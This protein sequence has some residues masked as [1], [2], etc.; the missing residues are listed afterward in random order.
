MNSPISFLLSLQMSFLETLPRDIWTSITSFLSIKEL[1]IVTFTNIQL[2]GTVSISVNSTYDIT[3]YNF[4]TV[5]YNQSYTK[6]NMPFLHFPNLIR[7]ETHYQSDI[8]A[9]ELLP[10]LESL[11]LLQSLSIPNWN[12][13][14]PEQLREY[15]A[16][17]FNLIELKIPD[18]LASN[19]VYPPYLQSLTL[20]IIDNNDFL[21]STLTTLRVYR[22]YSS[23]ARFS[24]LTEL[25]TLIVYRIGNM[26]LP[27]DLLRNLPRGLTSLTLRELEDPVNYILL[28]SYLT[29]LDMRD[30]Q[31]KL[32]DI[33]Y[34]PQSL[35]YLNVL[36]EP[37]PGLLDALGKYLTKLE[38]FYTENSVL[39]SELDEMSHIASF[40]GPLVRKRFPPT[41][42]KLRVY[43]FISNIY[44]LPENLLKLDIDY[45]KV[46]TDENLQ[47]LSRELQSL[48][49][50]NS[51]EYPNVDASS[52]RYLPR[53]LTKLRVSLSVQENYL[54][55]ELLPPNLVNLIMNIYDDR[56]TSRDMAALP[57]SLTALNVRVGRNIANKLH[58]KAQD[59]SYLPRG[60]RN[61]KLNAILPNSEITHLPSGLLGLRVREPLLANLQTER[62]L[63]T[64]CPDLL[65]YNFI[66]LQC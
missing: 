63:L 22:F 20:G 1:N 44:T 15:F 48:V 25:T 43:Y 38:A 12:I 13:G 30:S 45:D 64:Q 39:T 28:P 36:Q 17:N 29:Y 58:L 37:I 59:L 3:A 40:D 11:P 46:L 52:L 49:I 23:F 62:L 10:L 33:P 54:G 57:R 4:K 41:L 31:I 60:L 19:I 42:T 26:D 14:D 21:P 2:Y 53:G 18:H 5:L 9:R 16:N 24:N 6:Y 7:L 66:V 27:D 50:R 56:F 61:L 51:N 47:S 35:R 55:L 65:K 34:L 32:S 8:Y